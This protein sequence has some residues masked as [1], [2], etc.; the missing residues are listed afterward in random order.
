MFAAYNDNKP[1]TK[2]VHLSLSIVL[3]FAAIAPASAQNNPEQAAIR[4]AIQ[5]QEA[6]VQLRQNLEAGQEAQQKG[7]HVQAA[8]LFQE[9][10]NQARRVGI[11]QDS[12]EFQEAVQGLTTSA[13]HL[14]Q[15]AEAQGNYK[16][17]LNQVNRVLRV[18]PDNQKVQD[19]K[20]ELAKAY[21]AQRGSKPSPEVLNRLPEYREQQIQTDVLVRDAKFLLDMGRLEEA[22]EKLK[23]AFR[24]D[25][26]HEAAAYYL[27]LLKE[28]KFKRESH[29]R[30]ISSKQALVDVTRAWNPPVKREMLPEPNPVATNN[31]THIG[32]GRHRIQEKLRSIVINEL[33]MPSLPLT[34]VVRYL[35]DESRQRDPDQQ[36]VNFQISRAAAGSL[37]GVTFGGPGGPG[38]FGGP[39]AAPGGIDPVTGAPISGPGGPGGQQGVNLDSVLINIDPPL[40][41]VTLAQALDAIIMTADQPLEY[42][43]TEYAVYFTQK[44]QEDAALFTR[45]FKVDPNTFLQ[46]LESVVGIPFGAIQTGNQGGGGGLGGGGGGLGGGGGGFGGQGGGGLFTIPR[47]DV[48]GGTAGGFGGGVGGGGGGFGGGAGGVGQG[49]GITGVTRTNL[50]LNVQETVREFFAAA[51]VNLLPPNQMFFNDRTG[52]LW[53]RATQEELDIVQSA[54]ETLNWL[55]PQ[56]SIEAK[57]TEISQT[58]TKALGFDWFLGNFLVEGG[59]V[60][61]QGGSAPTFAGEPSR[62]N[63]DGAFPGNPGA[64][65]SIPPRGSD[66][67]LTGGLRRS[68]GGPSEGAI[69]EVATI[70]GILTDPQFR[71]VI[72]AL[73]QREGVDLLAS[74]RV[75]TQSGRQAQVQLVDIQTIVTG[76]GTTGTGTQTAQATT[77]AGGAIPQQPGFGGFNFSTQALPFGPVLDVVPYVSA[78]GYS[79]Q[80]TIIPTLTEFIGYDDPGA[81][82]PQIQV[83]AGNT[84]GVPLTAQLPLPRLRARQVT[85]SVTVWDGQTVVLGGLIAEDVQRI[86]DK[87]PVLGDIPLLGRLFRNESASTT[88]RNLVVFVT[89][90]LIDPAGNRIHTDDNLPYDPTVIPPQQSTSTTSASNSNN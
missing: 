25:P 36:G 12:P 22:E 78:D 66:Q 64:G 79:V 13:L 48:A 89:P 63:P 7:N 70:T 60:G 23:Q 26:E 73:E 49:T 41:N 40:R 43:I 47:V 11:S 6:M 76:L 85:T 80:M 81:F 35:T 69:P 10:I 62:A 51:G 1:M 17:A 59:A 58:D 74:P 44:A 31:I 24:Q 87:V 57:F 72:R 84:V 2:V 53:V 75:L 3:F 65:T 82:I 20:A 50:T 90:T 68:L 86:K 45:T 21:Q 61:I 28:E 19:Y 32:P 88:K 4:E 77:T 15:A 37:S 29:Q 83:A 27:K 55:P 42:S 33:S 54:M 18:Q 67:T 9:A 46:G 30:E 39:G 14:A 5:R 56:V 16:E 38:G 34:E 8:I 71:M 52:V